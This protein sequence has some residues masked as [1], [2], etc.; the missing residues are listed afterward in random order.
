MYHMRTIVD[1]PGTLLNRLARYCEE[2][3][4]SRAEAVRRAVSAFLKDFESAKRDGDAFG[5]WS[6][7][8]EGDAL[9]IERNLRQEWR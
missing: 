4:V 7:R 6:D 8:D 5:L 1:F 3:R 9:Q 2:Q